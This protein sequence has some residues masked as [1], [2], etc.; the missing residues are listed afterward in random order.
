MRIGGRIE[1]R[2]ADGQK[3]ASISHP[4]SCPAV[5]D[6]TPCELVGRRGNGE[7][8]FDAGVFI[9]CGGRASPDLLSREHLLAA[10]SPSHS[11]PEMPSP[12]STASSVASSSD[13]SAPDPAHPRRL[14]PPKPLFFIDKTRTDMLIHEERRPDADPFRTPDSSVPG[15]PRLPTTDIMSVVD[16]P[17]ASALHSRMHSRV[18]V[19]SSLKSTP[20]L[21]STTASIAR[22]STRP[23]STVAFRDSF[24]SP[25]LLTKRTPS[26]PHVPTASSRLSLAPSARPKRMRSTMLTPDT[27]LDKPWIN[28][29]DVH[30]RIA[31]FLTYAVA[32]LGIAGSV[33]RCWTAWKDVQ[34]VGDLCLVMQDE[35][36]TLDTQYTWTREVDMSGF[37]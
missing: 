34:R 16:T 24:M 36:D 29:K 32:F 27:K 14:A 3:R 18:S 23:G 28:A 26:T 15:T 9:R 12:P 31:Y 22:G 8:S 11:Q 21:P 20:D 1:A 25:P 4:T 30:G 10:T 35:F 7:W 13:N 19:N 37:G 5:F 17:A 33:I 2:Y 6:V